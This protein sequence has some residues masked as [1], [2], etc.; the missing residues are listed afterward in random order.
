MKVF[1]KPHGESPLYVVVDIKHNIM[2]PFILD[3]NTFNFK[4]Q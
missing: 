4:T 3:C 2:K 1:H